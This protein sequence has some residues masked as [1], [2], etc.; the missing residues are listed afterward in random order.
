MANPLHRMTS[1]SQVNTWFGQGSGNLSSPS[2]LTSIPVEYLVVGAGGGGSGGVGGAYSGSGGAGG[3]VLTGTIN[4]QVGIPYG[5]SIGVGGMGTAVGTAGAG[6]STIFHTIIATGG[7]GSNPATRDGASNALYVGGT[8]GSGGNGMGG[9]GAG[10]SGSGT[11]GGIGVFSS[12]TGS[13][14]GYG[15]GAGG[16]GVAGTSGGGTGANGIGTSGSAYT[17]G[18]GGGGYNNNP[19]GNGGGGI[20]ILKY[21]NNFNINTSASITNFIVNPSGSFFVARLRIGAGTVSWA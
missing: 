12:I 21:P 18:G 16:T 1:S 11:T 3:I 20:V 2:R 17:G 5:V 9:A 7:N 19:N 13:S 6:A 14:V 15:G 8:A 4:L 10:G